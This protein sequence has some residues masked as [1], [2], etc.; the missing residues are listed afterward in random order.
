MA[1]EETAGLTI[2]EVTGALQRRW[3]VVALFVAGGILAGG[4]LVMRGGRS[5]R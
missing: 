1:G 4:A 2:G 3:K 5:T